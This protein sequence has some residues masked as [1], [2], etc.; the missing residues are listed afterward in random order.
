MPTCAA[1]GT[2]L[3]D[4]RG[5]NQKWVSRLSKQLHANTVSQCHMSDRNS[6]QL[7]SANR[8]QDILTEPELRALLAAQH[9]PN[10][11]MSVISTAIEV[12]CIE[13]RLRHKS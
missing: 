2:A 13:V 11:V 4:W 1:K 5:S 12:H 7:A 10:Y 3:Q 8:T 6:H 9:R